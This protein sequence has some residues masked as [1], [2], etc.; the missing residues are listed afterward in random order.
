MYTTDESM[1]EKKNEFNFTI[2]SKEIIDKQFEQIQRE[3]KPSM[4]YK[5]ILKKFHSISHNRVLP[6][7]VYDSESNEFTIFRITNIWKGFNPDDPNSYSYNPNPKNNGRAHLKGSPVF[8]GAMDPFTAFAE[9]KDSIDIDQKFYLSRWK[10]KFKTN[11]NAHSLIINSTTK[12]RGHILNSAIKN[13]QEML[14]GMVKNLPNKQKEGFIYAIEKMGDL[15]TTTGSDNYHITSAYSHDLLYDKKEKGIDIPILMYP[16]VENK[17][18]SVNWAIHPS[19][20]NSKNMI[21]QDVFELCFKEKRSNDK[22]ESIKVSIHRKGELTDECII[23]WQVPHFTDFKINFSNLKVQTFNNEIIAG[24]DVAD[25]TINDTIYT[26]KNLIEKNVDRKFVQEELPKLS[27]DPEK[28]FSLDFDKEEFNSSLILEL[29]HG[30]EILTQIGKSCIKYIQV[31]ISWT[32][33]YKSI[34]N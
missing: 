20:V 31:P 3:L 7:V 17:F 6:T 8:Y 29:K 1:N 19:F 26:I 13:G 22:N 14:K 15:F 32:K 28:D 18:N 4:D 27:F 21:L 12:D 10:V 11:T 2:F 33:G 16:S 25:R 30:N 24:N 34:Q 9:M 5:A 23:N